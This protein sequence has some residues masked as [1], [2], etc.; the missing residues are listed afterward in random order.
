MVSFILLVYFLL[1]STSPSP[2][3][4]V[5]LPHFS[6][7]VFLNIL[8]SVRKSHSYSCL[9]DKIP[10]CWIFW[11]QSNSPDICIHKINTGANSS[12]SLFFL[13]RKSCW[14]CLLL[15]GFPCISFFQTYWNVVYTAS[16]KENRKEWLQFKTANQTYYLVYIH[17]SSPGSVNVCRCC[18]S[19]T[20]SKIADPVILGK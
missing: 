18:P 17:P 6:C 2:T 1:L 11:E 15:K 3:P 13:F 10:L 9:S 8:L 16:R 4:S 20:G 19:V 5:S 12:I 14:I 7:Y